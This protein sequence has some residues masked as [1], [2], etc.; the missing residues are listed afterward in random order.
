MVAGVREG[1]EEEPG[2]VK[3][4][5]EVAK[6]VKAEV[7]VVD[8]ALKIPPGENDTPEAVVVAWVEKRV[9]AA[10]E[11]GLD[12]EAPPGAKERSKEGDPPAGGEEKSPVVRVGGE[13]V[14]EME[15]EAAVVV[16]EV[17]EADIEPSPPNRLLVLP[18]LLAV[19]PKMLG[20][21]ALVLA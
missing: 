7:E 20:V 18:T 12:P 14:A 2:E 19:D 21:A 4:E 1:A 6:L 9:G 8:E 13:E 15:V 11:A 10:E 3:A 17:E 5:L 16:V